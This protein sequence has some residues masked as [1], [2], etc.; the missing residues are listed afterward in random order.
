VSEPVVSSIGSVVPV[1]SSMGPVEPVVLVVSEVVSPV[2]VVVDVASVVFVVEVE[3]EAVESVV[4]GPLVGLDVMLSVPVPALA[5][6]VW[7]PVAVVSE[8][9]VLLADADEEL[10]PSVSPA[11]SVDPPPPPH[12]ASRSARPRTR[13]RSLIRGNDVIRAS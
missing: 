6:E 2:V 1:L 3:L 11:D 4:V 8:P 12:A 13:G 7:P 10:P 9:P 5:L